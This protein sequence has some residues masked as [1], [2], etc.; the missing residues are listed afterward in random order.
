MSGHNAEGA[1][2]TVDGRTRGFNLRRFVPLGLLLAGLGGFFLLGFDQYVSFSALSDN[3]EALNG[4]VAENAV[5]AG[6]IYFVSY[7]AMTALSVP[8]GALLTLVGGFLFGLVW[9]SILVIGGATVGAVAVF[10][11]A[12]TALG[13]S[14]RRRAGPWVGRLEA[15]FRRDAVSYMLTLRLIPLVPFWLVNLVPAFLGVSLLTYTLTTLVG[16]IPGT[17]VYVAV[18]NGLGATLDSGQQPDLGIIFEPTIL[19]P[20][21]G[22]GLLAMLPV[23]YK[24]LRA[25]RG[26]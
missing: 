9:A 6:L 25:R 17:I 13:D 2:M 8:G 16:I 7:A 24:R 14:L 3:R 1:V 10:L 5:A 22:L 19:L 12:R 15:G 11:A 23:V 26:D 21:I 20:L 18:G 4:F